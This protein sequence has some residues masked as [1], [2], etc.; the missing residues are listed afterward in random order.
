MCHSDPAR[1]HSVV[2]DDGSNRAV[3]A[4]G[5]KVAEVVNGTDGSRPFGLATVPASSPTASSVPFP[6]AIRSWRTEP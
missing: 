6:P 5:D 2:G 1:S 4:T 3:Q